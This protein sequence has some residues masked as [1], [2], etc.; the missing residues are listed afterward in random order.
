VEK[1]LPGEDLGAR[2]R[3]AGARRL[4]DSAI[5]F[6]GREVKV[7]FED[8]ITT[9]RQLEVSMSVMSSYAQDIAYFAER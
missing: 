7:F 3:R 9:G 1:V 5:Y 2:F 6:F 8:L 4:Q